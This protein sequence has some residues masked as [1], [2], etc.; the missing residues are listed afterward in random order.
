MHQDAAVSL[1]DYIFTLTNRPVRVNMGA[2]PDCPYYKLIMQLC[3]AQQWSVC[4]G[5]IIVYVAL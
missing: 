4:P 1:A 3:S 5:K 2:A